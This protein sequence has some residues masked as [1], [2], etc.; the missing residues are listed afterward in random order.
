MIDTGAYFALKVEILRSSC[1]VGDDSVSDMLEAG[2]F[3]AILN[4][5]YS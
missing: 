2:S 3:R 4:V 5:V 1:R